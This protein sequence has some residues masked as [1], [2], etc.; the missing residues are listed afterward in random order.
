M[1]FGGIL[2]A[3]AALMQIAREHVAPNLVSIGVKK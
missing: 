1:A 2:V 3:V